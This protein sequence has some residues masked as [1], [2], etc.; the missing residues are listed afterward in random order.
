MSTAPEPGSQG[1]APSPAFAT[2]LDTLVRARYPLIYLVTW[3]EQRLNT[4]LQDL[5]TAHGKALYVWTATRGLKR[6]GGA[7]SVGAMENTTEPAAALAAV[8][9]LGE[10]SLVVLKDFHPYLDSPIVVRAL[11]DLAHLLKSTYTT[12]I[13]LS[14]QLRIPVELEK[15]ISVLDVPLPSYRDLLGLLR[16]IVSVVR[17]NK[18][19]TVELTREHAEQLIKAAQGLT[20]S[21]AENAF[22]R[23]IANDGRLDASD[24]QLVLDEKRQVIRKSGLLEYFPADESLQNVGGLE[25]LKHWLARRGTAFGE[26]ARAFGLPEPRGL[27]LLGVQGCGKSLTAKA[28]A[29]QWKLPLLRLDMGRIFSG[30][31]GSSEENLRKAIRVAE[32]VAPAVLWVDEIEKGMSGMGSSDRTDGGVTARV[33]GAFLTWLQEK[34]APVFVVAT[35]NRIDGLP[36]ELLRKGRFDEIFFIDLPGPR[37]REEIFRIH[38]ARRRRNPAAYDLG[39]LAHLAEHFSGAEI[40]QAV[41]A[42]LYDAFG[43]GAELEQRHLEKALQETVPLAT[44]MRE[45]IGRLRAWAGTRTRPA[46]GAAQVTAVAAR[47]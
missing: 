47:S 1:A 14:P 5:A 46:S 40:E 28:I 15:E 18:R 30:L 16:E 26:Q 42:A 44:T 22:A 25:N 23:A 19:A 43:E 10:P 34:T 17:Q 9:R 39:R 13:L 37:E 3:E 29:S 45:E 20:L 21:E 36:P 7:R 2:E 11:R 4:I 41:I 6:S 27:L 12:I 32:S 35:A 31:I 33:F 38:V 24:I 8:E